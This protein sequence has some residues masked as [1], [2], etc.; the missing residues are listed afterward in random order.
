MAL[1]IPLSYNRVYSSAK[2]IY[3]G[4]ILMLKKFMFLIL[5]TLCAG[6]VSAES[7]V[8]SAEL[9][10]YERP[11]ETEQHI[12]TRKSMKMFAHKTW[13]NTTERE[14]AHE[15]SESIVI[16]EISQSSLRTSVF[17]VIIDKTKNEFAVTHLSVGDAED[18]RRNPPMW[19]KCLLLD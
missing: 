4:K 8:C 19:G 13:L 7:Y 18:W 1:Q 5:F 11:G 6:M 16:T 14:V 10:R 15:S 12:F 9:S 2:L 3:E 17:T